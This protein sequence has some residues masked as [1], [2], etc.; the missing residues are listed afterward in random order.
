MYAACQRN[1]ETV[2]NMSLSTPTMPLRDTAKLS[3][4]A[5]V[6]ATAIDSIHMT[7]AKQLV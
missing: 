2:I 4:M 7:I 1:P 3:T 6:R 5:A